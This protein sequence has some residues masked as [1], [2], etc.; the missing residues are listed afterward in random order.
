MFQPHHHSVHRA[1]S[2]GAGSAKS[3]AA[4]VPGSD[5]SRPAP[6]AR[7]PKP[8]EAGSADA[9]VVG[10]GIVGLCSALGLSD[11]GLRVCLIGEARPGEA[12]PAAAGIL[13]P[14]LED[15]YGPHTSELVHAFALA[16]R[17]RYVGYLSDLVERSGIPVSFNRLGILEAAMDAAGAEV[18]R[19][20]RAG[21]WVDGRRLTAL[22]PVLDQ[23]TG[24]IFFE[25]DG[26]VDNVAMLRALRNA[27]ECASSIL[28]VHGTVARVIVGEDRVTCTT[29]AG[30]TYYAPRAVL[31]AGA[32]VPEIG[33]LP[34]A[35]P[36]SP[37]R[38]QMLAVAAPPQRRPR[39]VI[40]GPK[41]YIVPRGERIVIG[42]T[43]ERVGFDVATTPDALATLH[44]GG[45]EIVPAIAQAPMLSS[46]AGLRPATPDL[47]PIIG[48][49]PDMPAL[50]YACGH[51]R[52]GILMAPLTADCITAFVVGEA[53]SVDVSPFRV[54]RFPVPLVQSSLGSSSSE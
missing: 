34:R 7:S 43:L 52:N 13:G 1:R 50:I 42:A 28:Y 36:I 40:Y 20:S 46:W 30:E 12:S 5:R 37:L 33:G 17:D 29:A 31:A 3:R 9:I 51:S 38:G 49:D 47:L 16:A 41:A 24:A 11:R 10:A 15:T 19:Q 22:E 6:A 53:P 35:L 27:T 39:H 18:L 23:A 14:S 32:W 26:A 44:A 2:G 21:E 25:L 54:D 4:A 48:P 8:G 45:S